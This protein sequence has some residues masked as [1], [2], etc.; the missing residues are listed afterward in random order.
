MNIDRTNPL[1]TGVLTRGYG[2]V[3]VYEDT[4]YGDEV[5]LLVIDSEGNEVPNDFYDI[6]DISTLDPTLV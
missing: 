1:R 5:P 2:R 6:E 3:S 4:R